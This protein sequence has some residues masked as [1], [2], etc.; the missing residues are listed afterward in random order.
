MKKIILTAGLVL[1][2]ITLCLADTI[3][4][5]D[6]YAMIQTGIDMASAGDTVKVRY[7]TYYETLLMAY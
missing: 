6:D 2:T 1:F 4:I 5:P 3:I 7:G